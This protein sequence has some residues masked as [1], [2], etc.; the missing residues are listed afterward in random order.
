MVIQGLSHLE[1]PTADLSASRRFYGE[2]LGLA[3]KVE[4][5]EFIEYDAVTMRLR[6]FEV[7]QVQQRAAMRF[8]VADVEDSH[9]ALLAAGAREISPPERTPALELA[10]VVL[11][12]SGHQVTMWR[13]LSE[14]EFGFDPPIP[15][16]VEGWTP[17]A[18]VLLKSLLKSVPALFRG[19]A[20][21][22]TVSEAEAL[23]VR[24]VIGREQVIRGYI[25][26]SSR[27]TRGRLHK[28]LREH[29]IDPAKY[30][31]DFD[32]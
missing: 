13:P 3:L 19:L 10:A 6:L 23:A 12:P 21:R 9:R 28:P 25:R 20:R 15:T 7:S 29:G 31:D 17:E 27:P 4:R 18:E 22:K 16:T 11:D 32:A 14:D 24:G 2:V 8:Q 1:L 30:Q 5:A 26:A